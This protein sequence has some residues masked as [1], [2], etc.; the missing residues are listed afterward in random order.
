MSVPS[1]SNEVDITIGDEVD[2]ESVL[3][4]TGMAVVICDEQ[5]IISTSETGLRNDN[6]VMQIICRF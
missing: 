1:G 6:M 4:E 3:V 2:M 5:H